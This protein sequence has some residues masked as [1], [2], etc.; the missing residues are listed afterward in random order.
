MP[1]PLTSREFFTLISSHEHEHGFVVLQLPVPREQTHGFVLGVYVAVESFLRT[2]GTNDV[3]WRMATATDPR[4]NIPK[5]FVEKSMPGTVCED[6]PSFFNWALE[7]E[8]DK[9]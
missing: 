6:V 9:A 5:L 2:P 8:L 3:V 7:K 1:G 4:G